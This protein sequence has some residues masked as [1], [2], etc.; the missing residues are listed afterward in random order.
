[1]NMEKSIWIVWWV[2]P[3]AW[4][5]LHGYVNQEVG[6]V[7]CDQNHPNIL[8]LSMPHLIND[9]TKYLLWEV[10]W[11]PAD[12]VFEIVKIMNWLWQK[13]KSVIVVWV[14]CNT[15]HANPI[16]WRLLELIES[17]WFANIGILNMIEETWR[18]INETYP[19]KKNI[20]IMSTTWTREQKIYNN[21][22]EPLWFNIIEVSP[23]EQV[24][25]HDTIY[26]NKW[27]IKAVSPIT[28]RAKINFEW[29]ARK[30]HQKWAEA[31]I[32]WCT[33][34]PIALPWK[35]FEWLPLIDPMQSLAKALVDW[36]KNK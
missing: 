14:P 25:L 36:I 6:R 5:L 16:F 34:I 31:L 23:E 1:M 8:H 19:D 7:W 30:L 28:Q 20:W 27:W 32:L 35:E 26:N 10:D 11:N 33:E 2:W 12:W 17:E 13:M 22:L 24:D 29:F 15:F 18:F 21:L 3:E 9:R 4:R